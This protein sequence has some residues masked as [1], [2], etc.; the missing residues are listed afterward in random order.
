MYIN[1][2]SEDSVNSL[3]NNCIDMFFD[4]L[5]AAIGNKYTD[6]DDVR[7]VNFGPIVLFSNY[8]LTISSGKHLEDITHAHIVSLLCKLITSVEDTDDLSIRFD[9]DG[10]RRQQE[11]TNNKNQK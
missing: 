5:H 1:I 2:P 8:K 6:D 10:C 4:V 7:L 11:L 9:R 3:L